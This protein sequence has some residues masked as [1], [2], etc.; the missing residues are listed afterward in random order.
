MLQQPISGAGRPRLIVKRVLK[1]RCG[2]VDAEL[3]TTMTFRELLAAQGLS[4]DPPEPTAFQ[5]EKEARER[6]AALEPIIERGVAAFIEAGFAL[7]EIRDARLYRVTHPTFEAYLRAR[8]GWSRAHGYRMIDAAAVAEA[9]S[10]VGDTVASHCRELV[11]LLRDEGPEAVRELVLELRDHL[12]GRP[13]TAHII[14]DAVR[15]KP[16]MPEGLARVPYY[17]Q[18]ADRWRRRAADE[19]RDSGHTVAD[20]AVHIGRSE[21]WVRELLEE[22]P[23][24]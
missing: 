18:A 7:R 10:P 19:I 5:L 23:A 13:L 15:R 20:V 17:L 4:L 12:R 6:L 16:A 21:Q 24:R 14:R 11:P 8:W 3:V 9:L 22:Y 1:P 2:E